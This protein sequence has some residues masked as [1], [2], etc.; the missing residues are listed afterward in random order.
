MTIDEKYTIFDV[1]APHV[2]RNFV[3]TA[4]TRASDM[5][6][7]SIFKMPAQQVTQLEK[8]K[9]K[10]YIENKIKSYKEQDKKAGRSIEGD[11]ISFD[12]ICDMFEAQNGLCTICKNP[13]NISINNGNVTSNL[14]IDR[15]NNN[16]SHIKNNCILNCLKCNTSRSNK[17]KPF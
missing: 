17:E 12:W 5:N 16:K 4:L 8:S 1:D 9:K 10:Q 11:Y 7:I 13:F 14:T 3:W 2:D 15:M 6:N